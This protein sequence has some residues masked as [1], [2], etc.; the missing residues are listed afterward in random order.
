[1]PDLQH[2]GEREHP[3]DREHRRA[4]E[5]GRDEHA[6]ALDAV[7]DDPSGE[8]EGGHAP[9]PREADQRQG[10]RIVVDVVDL[11]CLGDDEEPVAEQ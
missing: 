9:G 8:Q 10:H 6:P 11:P 7:A 3:G 1:V 5:V 4:G 2:A